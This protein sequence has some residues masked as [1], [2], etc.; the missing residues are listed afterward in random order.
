[1]TPNRSLI[2]S[3]L[4][5]FL[6][7]PA[8]AQHAE[9]PVSETPVHYRV[10]DGEGNP[11][12]FDAVIEKSLESDVVLVGEEHNDPIAH[13][14][15]A[16][17][18]KSLIERS[19]DRPVALSLEMF[20]RDVQH[21]VDEYLAGLISE[22][23]FKKSGRAWSNYDTDYKPMV[24][25]AID[26]GIPV[27][28][29]NAPRR[30]VNRVTREGSTSLEALSPRARAWLAPLP[31]EGA[32]EEY[33]AQWNALMAE[34]MAEMQAASQDAGSGDAGM[35]AGSGAMS[36]GKCPHCKHGAGGTSAG[37]CPRCKAK[38]GAAGDSTV[39]GM[40]GMHGKKGM[41][42][43]STGMSGQMCPRCRAKH[44]AAG[45]STAAGMRGMKGMHGMHGK[46]G[47]GAD[48]TGASGG[49][50]P[51]CK[52]QAGAAEGGSTAA[53][54]MPDD[55][56]HRRFLPKSEPK[57]EKSESMA[58]GS[59]A[60]HSM[61]SG[62]L[63]A[64]SLWDATMAHSIASYLDEEPGALVMHAV[65]GFHVEYGTG[66]PE[67]LPAYSADAKPLIIAIRSAE[68]I[69]SFDEKDLGRGDFVI[70]TDAALPRSYESR[71][72]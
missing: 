7:V 55:E 38:H 41:G 50:C 69:S 27:I 36:G 40:H 3:L 65:G 35:S 28:A 48:S 49:M 12:S 30:Y 67:Q 16:E 37:M 31:Y 57:A 63:D 68:G 62:M 25:A 47:M 34:Q 14:L 19:G 15:Q 4:L 23:H 71:T 8:R 43:D 45:D 53:A 46:K 21:V 64:Q 51:H 32:S 17:L 22:S 5:S 58:S 61:M 6:V 60:M 11:S 9:T 33:A 42:S 1:M 10:Y 59:G 52:A 24:D 2:V 54:G 26:A 72:D 20:E 29:A 56:I 39:A 44:G 13:W 66:I 18:L 70:L